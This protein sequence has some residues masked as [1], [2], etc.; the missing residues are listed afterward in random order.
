VIDLLDETGYL[1]AREDIRHS[2]PHCWRCKKPVVFRA[3]EQW[4][5]GV[6]K[7]RD[8][9]LGEIDKVDW[10]PE[11]GME[12]IAN[13]VKDR[14]DWCL[15]RQR[16][17]GVPLPV[18]YCQQ[19]N[20]AIIEE[21]IL[22]EVQD[23]FA[24]EGSDAWYKYPAGE[25]MPAGCTCP[26]CGGTEFRKETDIMDVWFDSGVS[27]RAVLAKRPELGWPA[28]LY[29][30]GSD[31]Y[32]G[33]FQTSMLTSVGATGMSPYK[34]VLTHGFT[35]D[36]EGRKMSKSL[37]NVVDPQQIIKK[38]GADILRLWV[39]STD[40]RSDI[41]GSEKLISQVVE[42][43]RRI[44][45]TARFMLGN[46]NGFD[47]EK[48]ALPYEELMEIDRWALMKLYRLCRRVTEAYDKYEFHTIYHSIHN[49]CAVEMSSF[50]LDVLK[51]R[52]YTSAEKSVARRSAQT[53]LNIIL[54]NLTLMCSP[55]ISH[56]AEE[57]WGYAAP[58]SGSVELQAWP[59]L[60]DGYDDK[61]LDERWDRFLAIRREALKALENAKNSGL[62]GQSLEAALSI[63][64]DNDTITFLE[65]FGQGLREYFI[66]S[67]LSLGSAQGDYVFESV[68]RPGIYIGVSKAAGRKCA[69]C[70]VYSGDVGIDTH[71]VDLCNRC[72]EVVK[73]V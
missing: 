73:N 45:N 40:F 57:I 20:R 66:V 1:M 49:F 61:A 29:L 34:Q 50:Y 56:T 69:R 32:R 55:M 41:K 59:E 25:I 46:L 54:R 47:A 39:S 71:Y 22:N 30:E 63:G 35:L 27:H 21:S 28:D 19:C 44:R 12:R 24:R 33:W 11:W 64:A 10:V 3:T 5:I 53:V 36:E 48:D 38:Y 67:D 2:Y 68:E 23:L 72:L 62:V 8:A 9:V 17:W 15:S 37:G 70:W 13:M 42:V 43:Y 6:N 65:S 4:F 18:F 58:G 26:D 31:Q 51:D 52:L 14:P 16:I 60:P 7:Y